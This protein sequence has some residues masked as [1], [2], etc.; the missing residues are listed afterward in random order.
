M[1]W[2]DR[3]RAVF[4]RLRR[5]FRPRALRHAHRYDA[6]ISYKHAVSSDFA[7]DF[8]LQLK[9]YSRG[10]LALPRAVFRDEQFLAPG[11]DL[12]HIIEK[13]LEG[14]R[15][16]ILLA[17]PQAAASPWVRREIE[18]WCAKLD[19]AQS[20]IIVLTDGQ[21]AIDGQARRID[22][23][24]T[25]AL[26]PNL[27][28]YLTDL[29]LWCDL[30]DARTPSQR[31]L[32]NPDFKSG[33][34]A[35]VARIEGKTPNE[36]L[37][38][39]WRL[40]RRTVRVVTAT[41]AVLVA[42]LI[43]VVASVVTLDIRNQELA[44]SLATAQSRALAAGSRLEPLPRSIEM[45]TQ[46]VLADKTVEAK[47]ALRSH[48]EGARALRG[49]LFRAET[50]IESMTLAPDGASLWFASGKP[51]GIAR[52]GL[53]G[54]ALPDIAVPG[55]GEVL[56]ITR[57]GERV[58][59]STIDALWLIPGSGQPPQR[60]GIDFQ[61]YGAGFPI[62]TA[63]FDGDRIIAG[64][65][66]GI[67]SWHS[68]TA[69]SHGKLFDQPGAISRVLV[70]NG[71]I[72]SAAM[73][74]ERPVAV[75]K[76][77]A[78][79][80]FLEAVPGAVN[81]IA[82]SPDGMRLAAAGERPWVGVW[83][84][85]T[86]EN[87]W[88]ERTS[89]SQYALAYLADGSGA[90]AVG[91]GDGVIRIF[92]ARGDV[93]DVIR[94]SS[95]ALYE[96]HAHEGRLFSA[97]SDG[98]IRSWQPHS[99]GALS[100]NLP[101]ADRMVWDGADLYG[102]HDQGGWRL[103]DGDLVSFQHPVGEVKAFAGPS[104][105]VERDKHPFLLRLAVDG[106]ANPVEHRFPED[107]AKYGLVHATLSDD[108]RQVGLIWWPREWDKDKPRVA[109]WDWKTG[110]VDW[111]E[112]SLRAPRTASFLGPDR[113]VVIGESDMVLWDLSNG[114]PFPGM[115]VRLGD[116]PVLELATLPGGH[117]VLGGLNGHLQIRQL[118]PPYDL[119]AR[120]D[121]RGSAIQDLSVLPDGRILSV[122]DDGLHLFDPALANL[123]PVLTL[124]RPGQL[125][126]T[127]RAGPD[128]A[129]VAVALQGGDAVLV[130]LGIDAWIAAAQRRTQAG[131]PAPAGQP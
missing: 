118:A 6:F 8:E 10:L 122:D 116:D 4:A 92:D 110:Q 121:G 53:D 26:P 119:I 22:W 67:V 74:A 35:I 31:S 109:I 17:S 80:V 113:L 16:L 88:I 87:A 112:V 117:L 13:A 30:S 64:W 76:P 61:L 38:E 131:P 66:T 11:D 81:E 96:L 123:G 75:L 70:L 89:A 27:A 65:G 106:Q 100:V 125:V 99:L 86:L 55:I 104:V 12:P 54:T 59:L 56:E 25:D 130:P 41:I 58:L 94:A 129:Q 90:F 127:G 36:L 37:G 93:E 82:I 98:W 42:L 62:L 128:M 101:R 3:L 102:L 120:I 19:R 95:A 105:V 46:A 79:P 63:A 15:Y 71:T 2:G 68:L 34:N 39:E 47:R 124:G 29:P 1:A 18:I 44:Q 43:G 28:Q 57:D 23:A 85:E 33:L 40:R 7:A 48:M 72:I 5:V 49:H 111:I 115:P 114:R 77:D 73:A 52:V 21:I 9:R 103:K 20:L 50:A 84:V 108:G 32:D 126:R 97:G 14:S 107:M 60:L 83:S 45:A 24:R 51:D 78:E 91:D 69:A